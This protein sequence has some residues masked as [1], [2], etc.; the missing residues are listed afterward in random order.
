MNEVTVTALPAALPE[1]LEIDV[2]AL[3]A[4]SSLHLTDIV[5]PEGVTIPALAQG[6]D[7]DQA[8]VSVVA[9]RVVQ[10]LKLTRAVR[11]R[12][13]RTAAAKKANAEGPGRLGPGRLHDEGP[14]S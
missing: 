3:E 8:V 14:G 13:P 10:R 5:L 6:N 7:H 1:Y 9:A 4:G 2:S 12:L 11:L